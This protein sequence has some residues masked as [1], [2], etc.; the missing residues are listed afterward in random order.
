MPIEIRLVHV[1]NNGPMNI[2]C[3]RGELALIHDQKEWRLNSKDVASWPESVVEHAYKTEYCQQ[4][5]ERLPE[6]EGSVVYHETQ[7]RLAKEALEEKSEALKR[8]TQATKAA[9]A[10]LRDVEAARQR[11][12]D[13]AAQMIGKKHEP[14][15][16][17]D[18]DDEDPGDVAKPRRQRAPQ[19]QDV[20]P[21]A[22]PLKDKTNPP[23]TKPPRN[24]EVPPPVTPT[25][26]DASAKPKN[27]GGRPPT[28]PAELLNK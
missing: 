13:E 7:L 19:S 4:H 25:D 2:G 8:Q 26:N 14:D 5:L 20:I 11:S 28:P 18:D 9:Q 23:P 21:P 1:R 3:K 27:S 16:D 10:T 12:Q 17:D 22:P 15:D 6:E 24:D